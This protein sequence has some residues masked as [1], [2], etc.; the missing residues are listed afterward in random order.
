VPILTILS[1][2]LKN[3]K[4]VAGALAVIA[5]AVFL[6]MVEKRG[7]EKRV[8]EEA[9]A[10]VLILE[11]RIKTLSAVTEAYNTRYADDQKTIS[12]LE[13]N[14]SETPPNSTECLDADA[15]RRVRAIR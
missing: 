3:W 10:K 15:A 5:V 8:T 7:Y 11:S 4:L 12:E 14:A 6:H 9:A 1:W 13:S 2:L